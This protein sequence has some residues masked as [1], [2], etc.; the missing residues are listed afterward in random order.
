[1]VPWQFY[2][3]QHR[4]KGTVWGGLNKKYFMVN[5]NRFQFEPIVHYGRK[6]LP[7]FSYT[8]ILFNGANNV[9]HHYW[10]EDF[11]VFINK[12]KRYL[13]NEGRDQ[14][15]QGLRLTYKELI[16]TPFKEFY[17]CFITKKGFKDLFVG[18]TL[19]LFWAFYKTVI[20]MDIYLIQQKINFKRS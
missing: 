20:A 6:L 18:F 14:F 19:S 15:N 9:L 5:R 11:Y 13:K 4:L 12:H 8:E 17:F 10:M 7:T 16:I 2:F 3:K 1:M